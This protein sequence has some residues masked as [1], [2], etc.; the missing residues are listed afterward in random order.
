[1]NSEETVGGYPSSLC[2]MWWWCAWVRP[3]WCWS[4]WIHLVDRLY[5]LFYEIQQVV[6]L[7]VPLRALDSF[8]GMKKHLVDRYSCPCYLGQ[9]HFF[10]VHSVSHCWNMSTQSKDTRAIYLVLTTSTDGFLSAIASFGISLFACDLHRS[11]NESNKIKNAGK[12]IRPW[13]LHKT[14]VR[15][16]VLTNT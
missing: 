13:M 10:C 12:K 5:D 9:L 2:L 6:T 16:I 14:M 15:A 3:N 4:S 1:M 8:P 11:N 7:C